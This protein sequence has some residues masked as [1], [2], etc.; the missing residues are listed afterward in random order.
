MQAVV[1]VMLVRLPRSENRCAGG[2]GLGL[3]DGVA[4]A[5]DGDIAAQ[6][7]VFGTAELLRPRRRAVIRGC[8][9]RWRGQ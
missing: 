3:G 7:S 5:P 2:T 9:L 6:L 1:E 8:E 4:G